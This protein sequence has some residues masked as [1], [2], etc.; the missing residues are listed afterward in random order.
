MTSRR[1]FLAL[2]LGASAVFL[3][4]EVAFSSDEDRYIGW[5]RDVLARHLPGYR[6]EGVEKFAEDYARKNRNA[7]KLPVYA[8]L[9]PY[10][11]VKH[12]LPQDWE[13]RI[14]EEERRMFSDFLV[15]SDFFR[16]R[17]ANDQTIRYLTGELACRSPF[18]EFS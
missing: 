10:V 1:G 8:A 9:E 15:G 5:I 2:A 4:G 13:K 6:L 11:D 18:A 12:I 7:D 14:E 3:V 17:P 16:G